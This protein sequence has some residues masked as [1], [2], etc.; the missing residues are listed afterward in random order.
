[1]RKLVTCVFLDLDSIDCGDLD[2]TSIRQCTRLSTFPS[3]A[4]DEVIER[5]VDA[6]IAIVN[7][8]KLDASHFCQLPR[9]K[10]VCVIATGVNNIDLHGAE[11]AG[12]KICNVPDYGASAVSQHVMMLI[13]A[14]STRFLD[15]QSDIR[16]G[17]WQ[18]QDQF[19]LLSHPILELKGKT[20]GIIGYGHIAKALEKL[21]NGFGMK[22]IIGE[23]LQAEHKN[24]DGRVPLQQLYRDADVISLH[25]PLTEKTRNLISSEQLQ[26]MKPSALLINAARGGIVN[27]ADLLR[28][29]KEGWIAGAALDSLE[30]EPPATDNPLLN[31][32]LSQ[33]IITPHNAWGTREARQ[34]L[35]EGVAGNI[36]AFLS[37]SPENLVTT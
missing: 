9:L 4:N 36:A 3:T 18:A 7:K 8:V 10:L 29:L 17:A 21:A 6:E 25:C 24:T 19:C 30:T 14:L 37:G 5:L 27:E 23:S 28:A 22:V 1:M 15:Y 20:L 35:V 34:R 12:I 13:L 2:F 16:K 26:A 31:S 11:V 33:L 32:G